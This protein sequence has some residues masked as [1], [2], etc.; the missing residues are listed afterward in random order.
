MAAVAIGHSL[1]ACAAAQPHQLLLLAMQAE[2]IRAA[3]T[4]KGR[5][6]AVSALADLIGLTGIQGDNIGRYFIHNNARRRP[7]AECATILQREPA[8]RISVRG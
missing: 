5:A 3:V 2:Y 7:D 8:A 1:A 4:G 6:A